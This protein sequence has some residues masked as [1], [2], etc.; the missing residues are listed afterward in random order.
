MTISS[1]SR[2]LAVNIPQSLAAN[3]G[4][5]VIVKP[6]LEILTFGALVLG[7]MPWAR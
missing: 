3:S 4:K 7:W 2:P 5:A 1:T 6:A